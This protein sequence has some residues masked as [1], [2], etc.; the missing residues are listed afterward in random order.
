MAYDR[1][2]PFGPE[3]ADARSAMAIAASLGPWVKDPVDPYKF[4][5]WTDKPG[6]SVDSMQA[7]A[8]HAHDITQAKN[9]RN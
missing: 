6:Q 9:G 8:D 7:I 3:R 1:I 5:L 2:Q 4:M